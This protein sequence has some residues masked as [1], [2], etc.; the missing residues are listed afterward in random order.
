MRGANF[1]GTPQ[2]TLGDHAL[3][4]VSLVNTTRL[5]AQVPA[6]LPPGVYTVRVCNADGQCGSLPNGYTVTGTGPALNG[7]SP[8]QG[9]NDMPNEIILYGFNLQDGLIVSVGDQ[10]L[11]DVTRVN[12]TQVQAVVP[13]GLVAGTYNISARNPNANTTATLTGVYS[14]LDPVG[15]DFAAGV[16]DLWTTPLTIRQGDTVLLGLNVHRQGGKTTRQVTVAFYHQLADGSLQL[17]GQAT[18]APIVPG[19]EVVEP[20]FVE[21]NTTGLPET[22]QVVAVID[23]D[24]NEAETTKGNNTVRRYFTLLPAA[25]DNTPPTI[26]LLQANGGAAQTENAAIN[27][28]VEANDNG[29]AGVVSMYL[30]EREFNSSAR[31]WVAIQNTGWIPFQTP[32]AW[33]LSS[34]GG[35]RY[36]QGWVSDS[37]GN[38]SEVTVKTRID[39]NPPSDRVLAGQVRIYRRTVTAGQ[40]VNVTLETLTGDAD[41]YVWRPDGNQSFVSNQEGLAPDTVSFTAP[42]SGDYQIEIFGYQTS[43]Y[44]L[45]VTVDN[46]SQNRSAETVVETRVATKDPRSQPII[47]PSN[48]PAGNAAVPVAPIVEQAPPVTSHQLYLP[49]TVR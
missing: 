33:S 21:W 14:V 47:H 16:E 3:T 27:V 31:Q 37:A 18:T 4:D 12:S 5:L 7:V 11:N 49:I 10:V 6:G 44:R 23:P 36:I 13:A 15:D 17:I 30:V 2:V 39:Y 8:S 48:E 19:P 9:Y 43:T 29:G 42:Q 20:V 28:T 35:V 1:S 38:I 25:A 34:R 22:V 45:T 41:L 32:F 26:T 46:G 24:S 40:Q